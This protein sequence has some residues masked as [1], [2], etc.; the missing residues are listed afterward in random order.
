LFCYNY[1]IKGKVIAGGVFLS[2]S[3]DYRIAVDSE[4]TYFHLNE[5]DNNMPLPPPLVN[6][7]S[8]RTGDNHLLRTLLASY[9]LP[10]SASEALK[11]TLVQAT[12]P[13]RNQAMKHAVSTQKKGFHVF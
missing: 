2:V 10:L 7:F 9:A 12:Y 1:S 4:H 13:D 11:F 6:L 8:A 5:L 3:C